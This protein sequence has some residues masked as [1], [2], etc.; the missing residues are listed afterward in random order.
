ML[1]TWKPHRMKERAKGRIMIQ[2][3]LLINFDE[4][5]KLRIIKV[6]WFFGN[7]ISRLQAYINKKA[8]K[9]LLRRY[10]WMK[11]LEEAF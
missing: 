3:S 6:L 1:M 2:L 9:K 7:D 11:F 10:N 5:I 4:R 8:L